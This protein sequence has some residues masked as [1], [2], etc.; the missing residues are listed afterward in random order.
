[1]TTL[2]RR[3]TL[4]WG[5]RRLALAFA[6]GA[7]GALAMAPLD[8]LPALAVSLTVAV[9]LL[10]GAVAGSG[11]RSPRTLGVAALIGWAFGFGYFT[12]GLWWLGS[13]FLV[14][15]DQFALLMPL[16]VLGLPAGLGLF[17]ALGFALARLMWTRG[18]V[19]VLALA[20]GLGVSEWL[21]GNVLTG[22]P[23]NAY[24]MALGDHLWL[25]QA[26]S[27]VGLNGLTLAAVAICAAPA[28]IAT[29]DTRRARWQAPALA[30]LALAALA[31]FG[32]ARLA[33]GP[34]PDVA[35][36]RLRIMQPNIPQDDKFRPENAA[37]IMR[38]YLRLSGQPGLERATHLIWPESSFPFLLAREPA[39]LAQIAALL[40]HRVVLV[41]GAV[42][43][44][45][46][47]P[48]ESGRRFYNAIQV[49]GPD[50]T[51]LDSADK[52]HLVP[53][54]EYL[55]FSDAL[56]ALGLRQ[57]VNAPGG[58]EAG[59][60]R[61]LLRAPG[62]PPVAPLVCYEAIFPGEV[63]PDAP[64]GVMLNVTNDAWFGLTPGPHQHFA[65]ARL[66][67]IEEGLPLVRAANSGI[68]AVV[69]PY[70][71]VVAS[72]GLGEEGVLDANLPSA[73][74]PPPFA[75]WGGRAWM[76]LLFVFITTVLNRLRRN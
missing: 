31:A 65:Q 16:G 7:A 61:R 25:A 38:H 18:A 46:P 76:A 63:R 68:S 27:L 73:I 1:M 29:G 14:E 69:D 56:T 40:D 24:G 30:A 10:D 12:A 39:A 20:A 11:G 17:T 32:A 4:A 57:F 53:F 45:D 55:P 44:S 54:G 71:R 15:P 13:A 21:R 58:F 19:R 66:R 62:L 52:V 8:L 22:F 35:G 64:V 28:T 72:L 75:R 43:A 33:S 70:G 9:W 60:H 50:G 48:G 2:A 34:P 74:D 26:A 6:A 67:A 3:V 59:T 23:W 41:T 42:R 49:V 51:V 5:W 37:A 47:L 36:V